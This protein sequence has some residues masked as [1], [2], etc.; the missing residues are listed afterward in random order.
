M[1]RLDG[2]SVRYPAKLEAELAVGTAYGRML[3][4]RERPLSVEES[5]AM[6][7]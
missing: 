1:A 2:T 3:W 6:R 5:Q 7:R 4:F